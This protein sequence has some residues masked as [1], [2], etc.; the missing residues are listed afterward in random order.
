MRYKGIRPASI[1]TVSEGNGTEENPYQ[2]VQYVVTMESV[3]GLSRPITL[4]KLQELTAEE[5]SEFNY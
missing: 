4:G 3:C 2:Y 5:K 1:V